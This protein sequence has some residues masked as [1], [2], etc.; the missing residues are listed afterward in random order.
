MAIDAYTGNPRSGKSY[1]VV[2]NVILPSLREGRHVYT[3]IPMTQKA[4]DEFPG[5]IHQLAKDWFSSPDLADLFPA[6]AVVA[7]DELWRRW[8]SG[9]KANV[10]PFKDKEFLAEHG[11]NVDENGNTTRVVLVTQDLAD[12]AAFARGKVDKTYRSQ[13]LDAVGADN[14][15]RVDIYEGCVTGQKPPKSQFIRSIFDKYDPAYYAYYSSSTKSK[16]G[17]VGNEKRADKRANVWRSPWLIA[18]FVAPVLLIP[19]LLWWLV[20]FFTSGFGLVEEGAEQ[21]APAPAIVGNV[22]PPPPGS[23][24][25]PAQ[26]V[27]VPVE[28][29]PAGPVDSIIWRVAGYIRRGE[30]GDAGQAGW[31]SV[32]GY[33]GVQAEGKRGTMP[34]LVILHSEIHGLRYVVSTECEAFPDGVNWHCQVDGMRATPWS[35]RGDSTHWASDSRKLVGRTATVASGATDSS[36]SGQQLTNPAPHQ[37]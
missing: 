34:D 13:K 11:H 10:F 14:R 29:V 18:S 32:G 19:L 9:M 15:F 12:I 1:S 35:G 31:S 7:L 27:S 21:S 25:S 28:V 5:Q 24:S 3:N 4:H 33:N 8:P 23:S 26:A 20:G 36:S 30:K 2:K 6:G 17:D 16:T 22:N 37:L